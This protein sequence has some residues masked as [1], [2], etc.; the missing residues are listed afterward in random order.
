MNNKIKFGLGAFFLSSVFALNT[1]FAK[2]VEKSKP[3][4]DL[5]NVTIYR[6]F[7]HP[8]G[9]QTILGDS[10]FA[11]KIPP[12]PPPY[13]KD[14]VSHD[15]I[16]TKACPPSWRPYIPGRDTIFAKYWDQEDTLWSKTPV[17]ELGELQ[18]GY[19]LFIHGFGFNQEV[20]QPAWIDTMQ[21]VI[22]TANVTSD[23]GNTISWEVPRD[24]GAHHSNSVGNLALLPQFAEEANVTFV[25]THPS[26]PFYETRKQYDVSFACGDAM[27]KESV[28]FPEEYI[29]VKEHKKKDLE[30]KTWFQTIGNGNFKTNYNGLVEVYNVEGRKV[31]KSLV[32][33][34]N[35]NLIGLPDGIYHA[36]TP[37]GI[38]KIT[39]LE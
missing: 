6:Q 35:L 34:K 26:H 5:D 22:A 14:E 24:K 25:Y 28:N 32:Q 20:T 39:K 13:I 4:D 10:I 29:A 1:L 15:S 7:V 16:V 18:Q 17:K 3:L 23:P 37:E 36:K 38:Y 11:M 31:R 12:I 21:N 30:Q 8:D 19:D 2:P 27:G 33:N 9:I